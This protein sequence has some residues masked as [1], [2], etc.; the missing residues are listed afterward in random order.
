MCQRP[1]GAVRKVCMVALGAQQEPGRPR[2]LTSQ[3][4]LAPGLGDDQA[5]CPADWS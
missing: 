5:K 3:L 4:C 2:M 1:M